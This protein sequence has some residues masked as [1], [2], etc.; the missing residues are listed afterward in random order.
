[1]GSTNL[2]N[3]RVSTNA[4]NII[5]LANDVG[6]KKLEPNYFINEL[7]EINNN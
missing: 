3:P 4:P 6:F 7:K 2:T 1:M 5:K